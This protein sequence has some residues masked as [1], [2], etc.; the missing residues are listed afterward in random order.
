[1]DRTNIDPPARHFIPAVLSPMQRT[2]IYSA[3]SPDVHPAARS[4]VAAHA[5]G[6]Q[7][8]DDAVAVVEVAERAFVGVTWDQVAALDGLLPRFRP[9]FSAGLV[10]AFRGLR[11]ARKS[12]SRTAALGRQAHPRLGSLLDRVDWF[13]LY[14]ST[15]AMTALHAGPRALDALAA[16]WSADQPDLAAWAAD[17]AAALRVQPEHD[18]VEIRKPVP[19]EPD[20][21][22]VEEI[23]RPPP[24]QPRSVQREPDIEPENDPPSD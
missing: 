14:A 7:V 19:P 15:E 10:G 21:V 9:E 2:Q 11:T 12:Y 1:M 3:R 24:P 17:A 6:E 8:A 4:R 23:S 18:G 5:G 20:A 16:K 13:D 22:G